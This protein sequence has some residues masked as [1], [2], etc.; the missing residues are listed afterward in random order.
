MTNRQICE[1]VHAERD[2]LGN[3]ALVPEFIIVAKI[4][5]SGALK[6]EPY[7]ERLAK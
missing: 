2:L 1:A 4:I 3:A 7:H 6:D 5:S